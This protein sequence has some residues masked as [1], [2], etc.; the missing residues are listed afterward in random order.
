MVMEHDE[1]K[2]E[3]LKKKKSHLESLISGRTTKK[4]EDLVK[5]QKVLDV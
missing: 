2:I 1:P 5:R 4:T 3:S